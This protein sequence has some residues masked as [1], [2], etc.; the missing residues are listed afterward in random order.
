MTARLARPGQRE[1]RFIRKVWMLLLVALVVS[2]GATSGT[3]V[4]SVQATNHIVQIDEVM[5]GANGNDSIDF[6]EMK[7]PCGQNAWGPQGGEAVG[8]AR[9]V[10]FNAIGTQTGEFIFP[11]DPPNPS[12]AS[13]GSALIATQ[14]VLFVSLVVLAQHVLRGQPQLGEDL[15]DLFLREWILGV[16]AVA[17]LDLLFVEQDDRLATRASG[18]LADEIDHDESLTKSAGHWEVR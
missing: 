9:L 12:C 4:P 14:A 10:F 5:A 1:P 17:V 8:R 15:L 13:P 16:L 2:F 11:S 7:L 3:S 18:L 6:V